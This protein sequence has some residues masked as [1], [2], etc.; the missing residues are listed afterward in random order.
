MG[1]NWYVVEDF[2]AA[3]SARPFLPLGARIVTKDGAKFMGSQ[4]TWSSCS[5]ER[6]G[7]PTSSS[8][9]LPHTSTL[10]SSE[11]LSTPGSLLDLQAH[12]I[13]LENELKDV[14]Q[15]VE[16]IVQHIKELDAKVKE[17]CTTL[18]KIRATSRQISKYG[19]ELWS[20]REKMK[21]A[22]SEI[23][24]IQAEIDYENTEC[25]RTLPN[26]RELEMKLRK[27]K[28]RLSTVQASLNDT[29]AVSKMKK[30]QNDSELCLTEIA[31]ITEKSRLKAIEQKRIIQHRDKERRR[32]G[33][34]EE[35]IR[36]R[37]KQLIKAR[38]QLND[39][40]QQLVEIQE[41]RNAVKEDLHTHEEQRQHQKRNTST[42]SNSSSETEADESTDFE[43]DGDDGDQLK[44]C[45]IDELEKRVARNT[46]SLN[47]NRLR[48][49]EEERKLECSRESVDLSVCYLLC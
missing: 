11:M 1:R 49:R 26:T 8:T 23:R 16:I 43:S 22:E 35:K 17:K 47:N 19:G 31:E 7:N 40:Q 4:I 10:S 3:I 5:S 34:T 29:V 2:D 32:L 48:L 39:V 42:E 21:A 13:G 30:L 44:Y 14:S 41:R 28:Q 12:R 24:L 33:K 37:K 38:S 18:T 27:A 9:P 46:K 36:S 45:D 25:K 6:R 20:A 15:E